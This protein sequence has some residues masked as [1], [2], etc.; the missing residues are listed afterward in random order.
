MASFKRDWTAR[1]PFY[2][3]KMRDGSDNFFVQINERKLVTTAPYAD[4]ISS[5][6]QMIADVKEM[7]RSAG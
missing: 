1:K 3:L 7:Q 4:L 5:L 2:I 6:E